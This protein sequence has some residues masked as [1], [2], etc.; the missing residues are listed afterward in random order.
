VGNDFFN[1]DNSFPFHQTTRGTVQTDDHRWQMV[2]SAG[3]KL[4][5]KT[6]DHL[7]TVAPVDV[8]VIPGNHDYQKSFFLGDVLEAVYS[9]NP[10]VTIN[11]SPSPRK[12]YYWK[13]NLV[14]FSHGNA[15][16]ISTQKLVNSMPIEEPALFAEAY[17]REW[18]LGDQ[19]HKKVIINEEDVSGINVRFMRS[20]SSNDS[21]HFSKGYKS[22]K[23]AE[24]YLWADSEGIE[25][26][27]YHNIKD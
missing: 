1:S 20:I 27:L 9:N 13:H 24:G 23:G 25:Q 21:W 5:M 11:N 17:F 10:N 16:D 4:L 22:V 19:H 8:V 2:Y 15:K 7:S 12:Y 18:H 3:R 6:I 14:G 26:I